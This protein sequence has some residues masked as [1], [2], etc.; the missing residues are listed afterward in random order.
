MITE[1][2]QPN[3][4]PNIMAFQKAQKSGQFEKIE[5]G[6]WV[7][8]HEGALIGSN[9][10]R[11][12]LSQELQKTNAGEILYKQV[13]IPERIVNMGGSRFHKP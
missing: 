10:D 9:V 7:A 11:D 13:G 2:V 4:D 1:I 8:F 12:I 6:T 5:P 3:N